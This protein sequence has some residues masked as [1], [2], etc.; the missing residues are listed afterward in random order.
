MSRYAEVVVLVEGP[1]EQRFVK[2]LLVPFLAKK[3]VFLTP[4]IIDKPGEK[5]GDIKFVRAKNDI[6]KHLKQR[7][8]TWITLLV[9]YYGIKGD[10]P[11]YQESKFQA[12]HTRKAEVMNQ[13]T[14]DEVQRLFSDQNPE[15]RFIPY[16]SMHEIEALYF[17]DPAKLAAQIG[18]SQRQID[19]I[20][21]ECGEPEK[22]NDNTQT[23]PSKRLEAL[24]DRFKK[25]STGIAIAQEI[26]VQKMRETCPLFNAWLTKI[27]QL[28]N[29]EPAVV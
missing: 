3:S 16:V 22:I 19:S 11:G 13:A 26:G 12:V 28:V 6:E 17:S 7:C 4:I 9:D 2:D 29:G 14:A 27:E 20:L 1:T 5:G 18:V 10:W 25:T 21:A 8:D 23:A 15:R 24:S